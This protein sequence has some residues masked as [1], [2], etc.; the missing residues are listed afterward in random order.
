MEKLRKYIRKEIQ[1]LHEQKSY[2]VPLELIDVMKDELEMR[3]LKRY[4]NNI[5]AV[6]SIPPSYKIFLHNG[7]DFDIIYL[8][9]QLNNFKVRISDKE[10]DLLVL[11]DKNSAIYA[12][13]RLL[14]APLPPNFG[15]EE[16]SDTETGDTGGTTGGGSTT[17]FGGGGDEGGAD[18]SAMEPDENEPEEVEPDPDMI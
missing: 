17:G 13:N 5:K 16:E 12:L 14:I 15:G 9:D 4:V 8:G 11:D 18:D 1:S 3:P 7:Q 2:P 6:N 10:Y